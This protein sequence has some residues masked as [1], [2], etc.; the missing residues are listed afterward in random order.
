M[1]CTNIPSCLLLIITIVVVSP[2]PCYCIDCDLVSVDKVNGSNCS[3][4]DPLL[5]KFTNRTCNSLET[6][7]S[8]MES[9]LNGS[10]ECFHV[11][12]GSGTHIINKSYEINKGL[13][14]VAAQNSNVRVVLNAPF[15]QRYALSLYNAKSEVTLDGIEFVNSSGILSF[16]NT[17]SVTIRNC[18]F[19]F[20]HACF[21]YV[22]IMQML[23]SDT[24]ECT[25][26]RDIFVNIFL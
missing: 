8:L 22:Q 15:E 21:I 23:T 3:T 20:V 25:V 4:L 24:S 19:R 16:E 17:T 2:V 14:L 12:V 18:S 1:A 10:A 26:D 5:P 13:T 9:A 6:V 11:R 7:F